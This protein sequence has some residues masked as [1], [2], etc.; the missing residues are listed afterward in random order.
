[1]TRRVK[2][3]LA[4]RVIVLAEGRV[5]LQH[6]TDPGIPGSSWWVT[7]G[8]GADPG[9]SPAQTAARELLEETGLA[10]TPEQLG[11]PVMSRR[12]IHGYSDRILI[13]DETFFRIE[14]P[15]FEPD[16]MELTAS[17]RERLVGAGWHPV[18]HLPA[19]LWPADL[20]RAITAGEPL[21]HVGTVEES[22]V[23]VADAELAGATDS[24]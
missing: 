11:Q 22:T 6:D 18:E 24:G 3:R 12:V 14:V 9:E 5:L 1:M 4:A 20:Y 10:V 23:A 7:P 16:P 15:P 2:L 19:A 13:Q 21:G 8:G 17:E